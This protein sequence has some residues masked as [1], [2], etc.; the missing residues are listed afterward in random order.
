MVKWEIRFSKRAVKD[1]RKI[2]SAGLKDKT[3]D[4][5]EI[6]K[7]DPYQNPPSFEKLVG[8]L[9]GTYSR[10]ISLQHRLVYEI[11]PEQK[12]VRILRLWTH[13]E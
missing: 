1:A 8:D 9:H 2:S 6:L 10:R 7:S 13:Y 3:S 12:I 11:F 4:L 5:L